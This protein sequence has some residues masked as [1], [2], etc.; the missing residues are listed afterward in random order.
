MGKFISI[1]ETSKFIF[2]FLRKVNYVTKVIFT[3]ENCGSPDTGRSNWLLYPTFVC[4]EANCPVSPPKMKRRMTNV[5]TTKRNE[6]I[7]SFRQY[8]SVLSIISGD[9][10][11][12]S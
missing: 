4:R 6:K 11:E 2:K 10:S 8:I 1:K 12:I 5:L 9:W 3:S 7:S